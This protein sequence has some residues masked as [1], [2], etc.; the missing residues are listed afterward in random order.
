METLATFIVDKRNLMF[1]IFGAL[2]LASLFLMNFVK[3]ENDLST[4]L[5]AQSDTRV[6]LDIMDKEFVTYGSAKIM[7]AN[8]SY[9]KALDIQEEIKKVDGVFDV[10]FDNTKE[11]FN[12]GSALFSITFVDSEENKRCLDLLNNI[13]QKYNAYDIFT[14]TTLGDQKADAIKEEM[15]V[16]MIIVAIIVV[17]VLLLTSTTYA[18]V[19]VLIITFI[20]SAIINKGSNFLLGTISYI[21]NSVTIILQLAMSIDYAIIL[22]NQ[23]KEY[24]EKYE[25]R[26]AV[27]KAVARSITEIS[28]SSLTTIGGLFAMTLMQFRIGPDMG[29]NLIKAI[30]LSMASVFF[31]M[32]GL[33]IIF[34]SLMDK[35]KHKNLIPKINK[36]AKFD[37]KT[38]KLM[39]IVFL[40]IISLSY[41]GQKNCPYVYGY[42]EM[43]TP[44]KNTSQIAE[45]MIKNTFEKNNMM[46]LIFPTGNYENEKKLINNLMN[47]KEVEEITALANTEGLDGYMLTDKLT[48]RQFSELTNVD[49]ELCQLLYTSYAIKDES[50]GKITAGI[51]RYAVPFLDIFMYVHDVSEDGY[52]NLET[53]LKDKLNEAYDKMKRGKDQLQGENYSR[54]LVYVNL[55][56]SGDNTYHF[57]DTIKEE[58]IKIYNTNDIHVAGDSTSEYDFKKVFATDNVVVNISSIVL[59]LIVLLFTFMSAGMPVLLVSIIQGCIWIN[60]CIPTLIKQDVFFMSYLVVSSIQMGAN[61]DYAVVVSSRYNEARKTMNKKEAIIDTMNFSFPT[62]ITSGP[63]FILAGFLISMLSSDGCIVGIGEC[64]YRGTIIS[65]IAVMF[66]LPQVL[67]IGETVIEKTSFK[68]KSIIKKD[69]RTGTIVV[70]GIINGKLNGTINGKVIGMVSGDMDLNIIQGEVREEDE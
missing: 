39:P 6:S 48:P 36:I 37:F 14:E 9:D 22:C 5:P 20:A 21:S 57:T 54:I 1:L 34:G 4:Y 24:R 28:A 60:F 31:L 26:E 47:Y 10:E 61:I 11:H 68:L 50:Y 63:M 40:L 38:Q 62:I 15:N 25:I 66:V 56:I 23:F 41:I 69:K 67:L 8:I 42:A 59:V 49:Y 46:A 44:V 35:T 13:K 33:L 12:D 19:P 27:I 18:E 45:T 32:P 16:I 7:I 17:S 55:P 2:I 51:S 29:I 3:V 43:E 58:A 65:I 70:D 53:D 52:V 30:L 64:L